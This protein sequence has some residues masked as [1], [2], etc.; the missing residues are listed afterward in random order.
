MLGPNQFLF[1]DL[2]RAELKE[3]ERQSEAQALVRQVRP[4]R[5][6]I[7]MRVICPIARAVGGMLVR[8]GQRLLESQAKFPTNLNET[9]VREFEKSL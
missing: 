2:H 3:I 8:L 1:D 9:F 4:A 7:G 6:A 5:S